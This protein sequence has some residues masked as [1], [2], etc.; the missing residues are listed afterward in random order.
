[1]LGA[2]VNMRR[3]SLPSSVRVGIF[4]RFGY[5]PKQLGEILF[6]KLGMPAYKKTK[7]GY[8]TNAEVLFTSWDTIL[9]SPANNAANSR[10]QSP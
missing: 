8:S 6:D 1:M 10:F 4:C 5:S 3:S 9:I 7:T 2:A